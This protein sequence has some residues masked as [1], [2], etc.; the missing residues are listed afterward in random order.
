MDAFALGAQMKLAESSNPAA[1]VKHSLPSGRP[2]SPAARHLNTP[3]GASAGTHSA[4]PPPRPAPGQSFTTGPLPKGGNLG[5]DTSPDTGEKG[6]AGMMTTTKNAAWEAGVL[7]GLAVG[8]MNKEASDDDRRRMSGAAKAGIAAGGATA[9]GAA[10]LSAAS[11][12]TRGNFNPINGAKAIQIASNLA[13]GEGHSRLNP[14]ALGRAM[15]F[16]RHG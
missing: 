13:K 7:E 5:I 2:E 10:G 15:H 4:L 1:P 12:Y 8:A 9:A 16:L 6:S 3:G 14:A 11:K